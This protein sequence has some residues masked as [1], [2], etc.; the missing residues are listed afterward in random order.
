MVEVI[1]KRRYEFDELFPMTTKFAEQYLAE[2]DAVIKEFHFVNLVL[3]VDLLTMNHC[4]KV[5]VCN[6]KVDVEV[7]HALC[8]GK[9]LLKT[10]KHYD[11]ERGDFL[12]LYHKVME[13]EIIDYI[14]SIN[15]E[16]E[17]FNDSAVSGDGEC[18]GSDGNITIFDTIPST[19]TNH[20]DFD[21]CDKLLLNQL[22]DEFERVDAY[23]KLIRIEMYGNRE[24]RRLAVINYLGVEDYGPRE[25]KIVQR[26][27]NRFKEF[28]IANKF[29]Y[30][31]ILYQ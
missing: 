23:G 30:E 9:A 4:K 28:L 6:S 31:S 25:R 29:D 3:S 5:R 7:L 16:K 27:K 15:T 14:R 26:T 20:K 18:E 24:D 19:T 22:I 21:I 10:L 12:S 8:V 11:K 2:T 1:E 13:Q 17:Q